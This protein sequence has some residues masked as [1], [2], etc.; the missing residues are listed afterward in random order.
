MRGEALCGSPHTAAE[1]CIMG[2]IDVRQ[3][4]TTSAYPTAH[5][6][7][8]QPCPIRVFWRNQ[9]EANWGPFILIPDFFFDHGLLLKNFDYHSISS[10]DIFIHYSLSFLFRA[11]GHLAMTEA[12]FP[13][14]LEWGFHEDEQVN[15]VAT[16]HT[17]KTRTV[18]N[19]NGHLLEVNLANREGLISLSWND[20]WK[21]H[22]NSSFIQ[23]SHVPNQRQSGWIVGIKDDWL[24]CIQKLWPTNSETSDVCLQVKINTIFLS[25]RCHTDA[26]FP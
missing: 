22:T 15:M 16:M 1:I 10:D 18:K 12:S 4:R 6:Q 2:F 3:A 14:L 17:G 8:L 26:C 13:P 19:V 9:T 11:S 7:P 25:H 24:C 21:K 23:V 5:S 20:M